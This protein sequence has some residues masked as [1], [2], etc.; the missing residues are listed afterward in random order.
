MA[1]GAGVDHW[2]WMKFADISVAGGEKNYFA[3]PE[4]CTLKKVTTVLEGAI[5]GADADITV[6]NNAGATTG[7]ITVAQS[8]SAAGDVDTLVPTANNLF[9]AGHKISVETDGASTGAQSLGVL[10]QFVRGV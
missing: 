5:S 10:L 3:V 9:E 8:G 7:V 1:L 4:K 6:K 2:V